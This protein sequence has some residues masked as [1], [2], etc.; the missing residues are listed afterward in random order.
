MIVGNV[1][2]GLMIYDGAGI[3]AMIVSLLISMSD[4]NVINAVN[5]A[6]ILQMRIGA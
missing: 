2:V 1:D 3:T 6:L 4:Q 5:A